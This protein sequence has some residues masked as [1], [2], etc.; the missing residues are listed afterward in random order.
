[1]R[2]LKIKNLEDILIN[3]GIRQNRHILGCMKIKSKEGFE[4]LRGKCPKG[5]LRMESDGEDIGCYM[6]PLSG[7]V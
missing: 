7:N 1:M 4:Y 2:Q 5:R 3:N 6:K